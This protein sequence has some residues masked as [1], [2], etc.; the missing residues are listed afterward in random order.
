MKTTLSLTNSHLS[1]TETNT[2][3]KSG[4]GRI[5]HYPRLGRK[6]PVSDEIDKII[7]IRQHAKPLSR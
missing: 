3:E 7:E 1:G 2:T 4:Y 6:N 5:N